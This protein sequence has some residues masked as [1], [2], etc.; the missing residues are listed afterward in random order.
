MIELELTDKINKITTKAVNKKEICDY[1]TIE[2]TVDELYLSLTKVDGNHYEEQARDLIYRIPVYKPT[3]SFD[4]KILDLNRQVKEELDARWDNG[5]IID[6]IL[7]EAVG[8]IFK[9]I[10]ERY[11]LLSVKRLLK[12]RLVP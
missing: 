7:K 5:K 10:D 12:V 2:R 9:N 11:F 8:R 1:Y 4:I 3:P 6:Y